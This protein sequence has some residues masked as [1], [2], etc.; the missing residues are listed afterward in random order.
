MLHIT[1]GT[2]TATCPASPEDVWI[3][4]PQRL[5][6]YLQLIDDEETADCRITVSDATTGA[7]RTFAAHYGILKVCGGNPSNV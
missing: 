3:G 1:T 4:L 5:P 7:V 6:E 2:Q